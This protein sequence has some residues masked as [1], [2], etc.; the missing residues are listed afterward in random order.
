[1]NDGQFDNLARGLAT[2]VSRR[3]VLKGLIG[4]AVVGLFTVI[5]YNLK[6]SSPVTA[7][8]ADPTLDYHLFLPIIATAC[9]VASACGSR[10]YCS[11]DETCLCV[12]SAEGDIRCGKIPGSCDVQLCQTSADCANLGEGYFCDTP[13]SGC[14]ADGEK[15]RC[16]A[17]CTPPCPA[18]RVCGATCCPAGQEC[19]GG[20]CT[21]TCVDDPVTTASLDAARAALD[22]GANEVAL[23]PNGCLRYRR[24]ISGNLITYE[25]M[26]IAGGAQVLKWDHTETQ[27]TGQQDAD[28]DGFFEWRTTVQHGT[29]A[30]DQSMEITE[31]SPATTQLTRRETYT[32]KDALIH[33]R[34]EEAD[35]SGT[36]LVVAE[37]D[38]TPEQAA[39]SDMLALKNNQ[40]PGIYP[41][42]TCSPAET[43]AIKQKLDSCV[44]EGFNCMRDKGRPDVGYKM[45]HLNI[46]RTTNI[47]CGSLNGDIAQ[48][49]PWSVFAEFYRLD[50]DIN[51]TVDPDLW[52]D[53]TK[54]SP[55]QQCLILWHEML[56]LNFLAHNP[57]TVGT[58]RQFEIDPMFACAGLCFAGQ[59]DR[60]K[61]ACATCLKTNACDARCQSFECCEPDM[62]GLCP[63]P[64]RYQYYPKRSQ[65]EAECPSGLCCFTFT[66][67]SYDVSGPCN[68]RCP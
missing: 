24:A 38:T 44:L 23:S 31:Y 10:K 25:E 42:N 63:C 39:G 43:Q 36:L 62:G 61:C 15:P 8:S 51:I 6:G 19:I 11:T 68:P 65:C 33:V 1:M 60:T 30:S 4:G 32:R 49:S 66:C 34:W 52:R 57:A 45:L 56:H 59:K 7:S 5:G 46:S 41:G 12:R 21:A 55:E 16:I 3:Q 47:T 50:G 18:E 67:H 53:P 17:P 9:S 28:L 64:C 27:S 2:G 48:I 35:A 20:K 14:C 22:A 26:W 58:S 54:V 37:F 40:M 29:L 13:N